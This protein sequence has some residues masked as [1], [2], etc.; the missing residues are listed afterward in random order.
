MGQR[1]LKTPQVR[2]G[3]EAEAEPTESAVAG[4][5]GFMRFY[6]FHLDYSLL[7]DCFRSLMFPHHIAVADRTADAVAHQR[8]SGRCHDH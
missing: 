1:K 5:V 2:S 3:E 8:D 6:T 7:I 4:P